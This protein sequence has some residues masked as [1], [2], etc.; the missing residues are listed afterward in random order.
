[1]RRFSL[2]LCALLL[3]AVLC[4]TFFS[5]VASAYS[6]TPIRGDRF[7]PNYAQA[8]C[9]EPTVVSFVTGPNQVASDTSVYNGCPANV[10]GSETI[11]STVTDCPGIGVGTQSL[12]YSLQLTPQAVFDKNFHISAGCVECVNGI[13]VRYPSF[14]L[15]VDIRA[16]GVFSYNGTLYRT[17]STPSDP[18]DT[19]LLS[20]TPP[21][22]Y[23]PCS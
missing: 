20:N 12:T 13:P 18:S 16:S 10:S 15:R 19:S 23:P 4:T 22:V 14:H 11:T 8:A 7:G 5:D 1:M 9:L 21:E 2:I 6:V 17:G 3:V